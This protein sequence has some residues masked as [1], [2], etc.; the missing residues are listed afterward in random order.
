MD[1]SDFKKHGHE[2]LDWMAD[3]FKKVESYPVKSAVRPKDIYKQIPETAPTEGESFETIFDDFKKII[4][5]GITHWNHPSFFAF[6]PANNSYP[7]I[8][9][10]MIMSTLAAQC[11]VWETS[12][13]ATELEER[14]M[15]WLGQMIG[16]PDYFTG[17]IQDAASTSTICSL[18]TAREKI[19]QYQINRSGYPSDTRFTTYASTEAHSCVEKGIKI[20]G[21]GKESL[22]KIAVDQQFAMKPEALE[23]AISEDIKK[24]FIPLCVVAVLG[25]TSS[26]A[27]DP[28]KEIG[29]VCEKYKVWLH[30]D[31]AMAGTALVLPEKRWMIEGIE[32]VD[33]F[34]FNPHKWMFLNA[35]CTAYFVKDKEALIRTFEILPE[36]LKTKEDAQVNNYRDWGIQLGRRFR[37]LKLWFVLRSFG[38]EGLRERIR[39]HIELGQY[40]ADKVKASDEFEILAPVPINNVCF[41]YKPKNV[42]DP[43]A[44]NQLNITLLENLNMTGKV[45]LS[46]TKLNDVYTIRMCVGQTEVEKRHVDAAWDLIVQEAGK[47]TRSHLKKAK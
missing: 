37:A 47:L 13:A 25:T 8:L 6:F 28:L 27:I 19:S 7:S 31:A 35:D 4:M 2:V 14:V 11:M 42:D 45:Y 12:P 15:E 10:E 3:Y 41:R 23:E 17:V 22:R 26:T 9:G 33:T 44:L 46:H 29:A 20:I 34:V 5:P 21:L 1:N 24:G 36:Y 18:L 40:F 16:L 38:L 30:V 39:F 32:K 43:E